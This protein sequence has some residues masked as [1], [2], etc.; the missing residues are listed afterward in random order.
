MREPQPI[1][2]STRPD[3]PDRG[4]LS[5]CIATISL[6]LTTL[7]MGLVACGGQESPEL[8][9]LEQEGYFYDLNTGKLFTAPLQLAPPVI[10]PSGPLE[11]GELLASQ[12]GVRAYV[13]AC[14][15]CDELDRRYV[16]WLETY[17]RNIRRLV[18]EAESQQVDPREPANEDTQGLPEDSPF[19][20]PAKFGLQ[21]RVADIELV[22][23]GEAEPPEPGDVEL[24]EPPDTGSDAETPTA[25]A[26]EV[27]QTPAPPEAQP[28]DGPAPHEPDQAPDTSSP[29]TP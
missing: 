2:P 10:A 24:D 5:A 22:V 15:A 6:G 3:N 13:F 19:L 11:S 23:E 27:P 7:A 8:A 9:V 16:G 12:A 29:E 14:G 4:R 18:M 17:T 28:E 1:K 25:D 20:N 21:S 26:P